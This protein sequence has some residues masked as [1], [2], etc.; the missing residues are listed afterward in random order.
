MHKR[1]TTAVTDVLQPFYSYYTGQLVLA[2]TL[3]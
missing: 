2:A 1:R 3:R